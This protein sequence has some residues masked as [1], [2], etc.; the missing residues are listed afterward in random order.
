MTLQ[1]RAVE[2]VENYWLMVLDVQIVTLQ[3]QR[4]DVS[5]VLIEVIQHARSM[6]VG[7]FVQA[8]E[9]KWERECVQY[10]EK[11]NKILATFEEKVSVV[12][13]VEIKI[14]SESW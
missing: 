5:F 13:I 2:L 7:R 6:E 8:V 9:E 4:K 10:A 11:G 12:R 1:W 14:W 3:T